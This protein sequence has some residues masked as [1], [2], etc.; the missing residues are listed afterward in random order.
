[1]ARGTISVDTSRVLADAIKVRDRV[2]KRLVKAHAAAANL[3]ELA[4][5]HTQNEAAVAAL[6]GKPFEFERA[7]TA[8]DNG[9][10]A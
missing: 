3:A 2:A 6:G 4:A 9:E 10:T 5:A 1:M 7:E 8:D